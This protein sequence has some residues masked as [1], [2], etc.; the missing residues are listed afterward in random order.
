MGTSFISSLGVK[1][2]F[3]YKFV[4]HN[5]RC[6]WRTTFTWQLITNRSKLSGG[7]EV[8]MMLFYWLTCLGCVFFPSL[9]FFLFFTPL[10][11]L[12]L[13]LKCPVTTE[14]F[15]PTCLFIKFRLLSFSLEFL[16]WKGYQITP[17]SLSYNEKI[18]YFCPWLS[19]CALIMAFVLLWLSF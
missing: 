7:E 3:H 13:L 8:V 2:C 6:S 4:L 11:S 10:F 1:V 9:P 5:I 12:L 18:F 17:C 14:L 16:S 15:K 19:L